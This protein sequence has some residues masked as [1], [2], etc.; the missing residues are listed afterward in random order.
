MSR[1]ICQTGDCL[2]Q[3]SLLVYLSV[4]FGDSHPHY[5]RD[6][7]LDPSWVLD[8]CFALKRAHGTVQTARG[9]TYLVLVQRLV[10]IQQSIQRCMSEV[11]SPDSLRHKGPER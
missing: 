9:R 4:V 7:A 5:H 11:G 1:R 10:V 3:G 2:I 6:L 8:M